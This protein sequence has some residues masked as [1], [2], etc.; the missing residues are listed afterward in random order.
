[1]NLKT[2]LIIVALSLFFCLGGIAQAAEKLTQD[3]IT[4]LSQEFQI[5]QLQQQVMQQT[6]DKNG[7]RMQ[8]IATILKPYLQSTKGPDAPKAPKK[9]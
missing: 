5:L 2:T 6:F 4:I 7:K 1:M 9:K 3:Q 8:E